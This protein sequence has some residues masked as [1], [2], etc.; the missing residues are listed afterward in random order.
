MLKNRYAT[1]FD[2]VSALRSIWLRPRGPESFMLPLEVLVY[3]DN[4]I[5]GSVETLRNIQPS[6]VST[7][8]FYDGPQATSRWGVGHSAG[9]IHIST[10]SNGAI[11]M[12][13][14]DTSRARRDTIR[15]DTVEHNGTHPFATW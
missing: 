8:R 5:L 13:L 7:V 1:V 14:P 4:T 2:A 15:R 12:P 11:G 10:W 9:V 6:L 3:Y